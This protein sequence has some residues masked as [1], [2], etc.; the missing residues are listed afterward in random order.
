DGRSAADD[1]ETDAE[2]VGRLPAE[3]G[4][5]VDDLKLGAVAEEPARPGVRVLPLGGETEGRVHREAESES[6]VDGF[7]PVGVRREEDV[8]LLLTRRS[9]AR[10]GRSAFELGFR[11]RDQ[12]HTDLEPPLL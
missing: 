8:A 6:V 4:S 12:R 5:K 3:V 2:G 11:E 10:E 7:D 9:G 1:A